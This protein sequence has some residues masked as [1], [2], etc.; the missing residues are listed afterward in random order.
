MNSSFSNRCSFSYLKFTI[1]ATNIIAEPK[2]RYGQQEQLT[3]R[4]HNRSTA[5]ERLGVKTIYASQWWTKNC[6]KWTLRQ[7][8]SISSYILNEKNYNPFEKYP[9][10][11]ISLKMRIKSLNKKNVLLV[12]KHP[13]FCGGRRI[14]GTRLSRDLCQ[15]QTQLVYKNS[16][17]SGRSIYL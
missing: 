2:Y 13:L 10:N 6:N 17:S 8:N 5:L 12:L 16:N 15:S 1:Y 9:V 14:L 7:T 4:N 3:V 11:A